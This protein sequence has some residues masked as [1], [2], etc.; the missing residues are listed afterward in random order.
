MGDAMIFIRF[1]KN[2]VELILFLIVS[3]LAILWQ[4]VKQ[5]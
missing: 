3:I 4:I 5:G 2:L 1:L